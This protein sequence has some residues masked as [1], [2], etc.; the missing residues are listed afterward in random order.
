MGRSVQPTQAD[1]GPAPSG[2]ACT[3]AERLV[4]SG[5]VRR[6]CRLRDE[7]E[8]L[9]RTRSDSRGFSR[10][11]RPSS[12]AVW[13]D[14]PCSI[15]QLGPY[16]IVA[17]LGAGGMGEV[18]RARDTQARARRGD[19]DPAARVRDTTPSGARASSAKRGCSPSLNHPHI[20]AIYGLEEADGVPALV[21]ELVEGATLA[22]RLDTRAAAD[23]TRRWRSRGRS[24]RRSKPRTRRA[25]SIAI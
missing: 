25:S 3:P 12:P 15:G 11:R 6:R 18:Y 21:L 24:P 9:L 14:Y 1:L 5:G 19:Q 10:L 17:P 7:L 20:G 4:P 22:E 8:S 16:T 23:R 2:V 13:P